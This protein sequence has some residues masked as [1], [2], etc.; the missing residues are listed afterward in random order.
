[1]GA[2]AL[3][4]AT[5]RVSAQDALEIEMLCPKLSDAQRD[6]VEARIRLLVGT[7]QRPPERLGVA[8]D[9]DRAWV[10]WAGE[11]LPVRMRQPL[12][13]EIL[14][15]VEARLQA[16]PP[17]EASETSVDG[18]TSSITW[19]GEKAAAEAPSD[20]N[21]QPVPTGDSPQPAIESSHQRRGKQLG[22][23]MALGIAFEP[24]A[25][26]IEPAAGP[27]IEF[28]IPLTQPLIAGSP[29][30]FSGMQSG[31][32]ASADPYSVMLLDFGAGFALGAPL[33]PGARFGVVTRFEAEWLIAYPDGT[34]A[35]AAFAPTAT[36]GGRVAHELGWAT[37]WTEIAGRWRMTELELRGGENIEA[38]RWAVQF[39]AGLAFLDRR[40][41]D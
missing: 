16:E 10:D 38:A 34:S 5:G 4:A 1:V 2:L 15:V 39:T 20:E 21:P 13:D 24:P 30:L 9:R 23:G 35:R 29:L 6:E 40:T 28:A 27:Y 8:C 12:A 33:V 36:L 11:K 41:S 22:G 37:L 14:D 18:T 26:S 7:A 17:V 25:A 3:L 32:F 31:R 19:A